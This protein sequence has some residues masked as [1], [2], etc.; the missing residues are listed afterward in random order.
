MKPG[1][2]YDPKLPYNRVWSPFKTLY[3]EERKVGQ[4]VKHEAQ[5]PGSWRVSTKVRVMDVFDYTMSMKNFIDVL[6]EMAMNPRHTFQMV[7]QRPEVVV[8]LKESVVEYF[9]GKDI[10]DR[11]TQLVVKWCLGDPPPNVIVGVTVT[12]QQN[13]KDSIPLLLDIPASMRMVDIDPLTEPIDLSPWIF[14]RGAAIEHAIVNDSKLDRK[15]AESIIFDPI[16]WVVVGGDSRPQA[17]PCDIMWIRQILE[18]CTAVPTFLWVKQLGSNRLYG[19][20]GPRSKM[21]NDEHP[22]VQ[23]FRRIRDKIG[24]NIGEWVHDLQVREFPGDG[25]PFI[26]DRSD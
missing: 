8:A 20:H 17:M 15:Q 24:A 22:D 18:L 25:G 6:G 2:I 13:A 9:K 16:R 14:D 11:R 1:M 4:K 23:T 12:T 26:S 3:A 7:V 19:G 5:P 10:V 21:L